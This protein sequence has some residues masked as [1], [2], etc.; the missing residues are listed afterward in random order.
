MVNI[1]LGVDLVHSGYA[2]KLTSSGSALSYTQNVSVE[3]EFIDR[4]NS[5]FMK[6][7]FNLTGDNKR[8]CDNEAISTLKRRKIAD[9]DC[10]K[11]SSALGTLAGNEEDGLQIAVDTNPY[12]SYSINLWNSAYRKDHTPLVSW[13][14]PKR[15]SITITIYVSTVARM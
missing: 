1:E 5:L 2:S 14:L 8:E 3:G 4:N 9:E 10:D 13:S 12:D 7:R 6:I 15:F 11:L